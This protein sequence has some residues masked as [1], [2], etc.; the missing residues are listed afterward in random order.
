M[1]FISLDIGLCKSQPT[2]AKIKTLT[3][4]NTSE[5]NVPY[6]PSMLVSQRARS[7]FIGSRLA[8]CLLAS[9]RLY[10][11]RSVRPGPN[12]CCLGLRELH[13]LALL[14]WPKKR[15][16]NEGCKRWR[17]KD[18]EGQEKKKPNDREIHCK[19]QLVFC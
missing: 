5:N 11:C 9:H 13:I 15:K 17:N 7:S 8:S 14:H 1:L 2:R 16:Q 19:V 12:G 4:T 6:L 3:V 18:K 10:C